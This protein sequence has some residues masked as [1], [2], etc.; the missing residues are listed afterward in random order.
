VSLEDFQLEA[1]TPEM[2]ADGAWL[3]GNGNPRLWDVDTSL[4]ARYN[5]L[6]KGNV[7]HAAQDGQQHKA[8]GSKETLI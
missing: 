2:A 5:P 7:A 8:F 6:T 1:T 4:A 3:V